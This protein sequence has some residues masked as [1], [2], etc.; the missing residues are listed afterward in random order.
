MLTKVHVVKFS[1]K[2]LQMRYSQYY[3]ELLQSVRDSLV[4]PLCG[5]MW[6]VEIVLEDVTNSLSIS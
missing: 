5:S 3:A 2:Y 6:A 1:A 4:L